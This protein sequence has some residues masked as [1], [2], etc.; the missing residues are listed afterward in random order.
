LSKRKTWDLKF[1]GFFTVSASTTNSLSGC[2]EGK[3]NGFMATTIFHMMLLPREYWMILEDKVFVSSFNLAP[4]HFPSY[5]VKNL[6]QFLSLPV[7]PVEL[8]VGRG[9]GERELNHV[10]ARKPGPL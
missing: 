9:E 5:P 7:S 1:L 6:S 10:T 8:T 4:P 2:F 3:P